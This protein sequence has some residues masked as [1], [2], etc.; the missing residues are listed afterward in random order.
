MDETIPGS[1]HQPIVSTFRIPGRALVEVS[2]MLLW[3]YSGAHRA[4]VAMFGGFDRWLENTLVPL[5]SGAFSQ[6]YDMEWGRSPL[7][8]RPMWRSLRDTKMNR[9]IDAFIFQESSNWAPGPQQVNVRTLRSRKE[10]VAPEASG[11]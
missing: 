5:K 2:G 1:F 8:W 6:C 10:V 4:L 11:G 7:F 9:V 3:S